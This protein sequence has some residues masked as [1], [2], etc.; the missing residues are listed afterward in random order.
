MRLEVRLSPTLETERVVGRLTEDRGRLFFEYDAAFLQ[1]PQWLSPFKL[2]PQPGL[3]E[4]RERDFGPIFGLFDDSLPDGWGFLLMDRYFRQQGRPP[5][6]VS[7]LERLAYLGTRTMG[8]LTYHPPSEPVPQNQRILDLHEMAR[9]SEDVL[10]GEASEILPRLLRA[11]G[12]PGGARPK[13]LVGVRGDEILLRRRP[14]AG[15]LRS[16]DGEVS[17]SSRLGRSRSCR[18]GLRA[19][20]HRRR[21]PHAAHPTV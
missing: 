7:V 13:V 5:R 10:R 21:N 8:S 17:F 19:P 4:H 15:W 2:P 16:L 1:D 11:G 3:I 18:V 20:G 14:F 9:A 6:Q 12:S